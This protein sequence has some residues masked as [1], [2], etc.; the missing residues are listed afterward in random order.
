MSQNI[1]ALL[2]HIQATLPFDIQDFGCGPGRDLMVFRAL[3]H[4]VVGLE[5]SP[6]LSALARAN[7]GCEVLEQSFL[8]LNLPRERFD[9]VFAN[10]V[11]FHIPSQELPRV[12]GELHIALKPGGV[13]L[14]EPAWQWSR[15][16]ERR[17]LW[18]LLR[19][20]DLARFC[21]GFRVR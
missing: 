19:L 2:E 14:L 16:L 8:E 6:Q 18:G 10:A 13:V 7:S 9:G 3:G 17:P 5:G 12:L 20:A 1:Q 15:R 11:L 4:R 21:V